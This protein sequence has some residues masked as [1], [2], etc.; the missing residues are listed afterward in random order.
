MEQIKKDDYSELTV[1]IIDDEVPFRNY[2]VQVIKKYLNTK[3]LSAGNP[4]EGIELI[5]T[6]RPDLVLLD[7][8]MPKM[9]GFTALS[10]I[11]KDKKITS[12]P[13]IACS[14]L[15]NAELIKS[16]IKLGI[17][18]YLIKPVDPYAIVQKTSKVLNQIRRN[19]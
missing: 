16:L 4:V 13:V 8:Q 6:N 14:A 1:L 12:T 7:M 10:K 15:N 9:D 3:I 17:S 5:R 11:R 18:D 2:L 19:K